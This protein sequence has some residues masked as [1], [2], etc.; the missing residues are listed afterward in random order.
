MMVNKQRTVG[1]LCESDS[2]LN[3]TSQVE[4]AVK[5]ELGGGEKMTEK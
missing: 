2:S 1:K 3:I 4:E 5:R